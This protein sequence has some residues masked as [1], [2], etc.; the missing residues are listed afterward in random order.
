MVRV[1]WIV[2]VT[3]VE[4]K[5]ETLK[6]RDFEQSLP[7]ALLRSREAVMQHFRPIL[8]EYD[9]TEQNWRVLRALDSFGETD[10]STLAKHCCVLLPSMSGMVKRLEARGYIERTSNS[11]DQRSSLLSLTD[12]ARQLILDVSPHSEAAYKAIEQSF[13]KEDLDKLY[14]LLFKLEKI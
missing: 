12:S 4:E 7:M 2:N 13:G 6:I 1:N 3:K 10:I 11:Q 5:I 9:L 8:S 14:E